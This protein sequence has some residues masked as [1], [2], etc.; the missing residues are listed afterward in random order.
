MT[1]TSS[2]DQ[3]SGVAY[4]SRKAELGKVRCMGRTDR[5]EIKYSPNVSPEGKR[6]KAIADWCDSSYTVPPEGKRGKTTA[7]W[8]DSSYTVPLETYLTAK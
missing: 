8:C 7:D 5:A 4:G 2:A 1:N 6:G 3:K